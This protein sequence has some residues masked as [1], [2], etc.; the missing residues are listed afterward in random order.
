MPC[1]AAVSNTSVAAQQGSTAALQ[2]GLNVL[3]PLQRTK[4]LCFYMCYSYIKTLLHFCLP[5]LPKLKQKH[6]KAL[7]C[8]EPGRGMG[9]NLLPALVWKLRLEWESPP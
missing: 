8:F 7:L 6:C 4:S 3:V 9:E 5:P 2:H 1:C